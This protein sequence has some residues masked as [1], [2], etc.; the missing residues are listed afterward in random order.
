MGRNYVIVAILIVCSVSWDPR[1]VFLEEAVDP[2]KLGQ[3]IEEMT[4]HAFDSYRNCTF[5]CFCV[6]FSRSRDGF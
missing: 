4:H 6:P 5:V 2:V 1:R 3:E